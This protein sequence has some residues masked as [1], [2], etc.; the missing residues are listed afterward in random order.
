MYA[1]SGK[2]DEAIKVL[3]DLNN[4][5]KHPCVSSYLTASIYAGLGDKDK[6]FGSLEKAYEGRSWYMTHL[7]LDP[8]LDS[9]HS[10]TRFAELVRR[11]GLP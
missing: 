3:A 6:A 9:L 8:E 5:S 7:R 1:V 4:R 11:V 2:K 10:D